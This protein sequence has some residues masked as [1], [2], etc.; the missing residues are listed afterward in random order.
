MNDLKPP[1]GL[2]DFLA[3]LF[4]GLLSLHAIVLIAGRGR[5]ALISALST[6]NAAFDAGLIVVVA[7][8][9]GLT[10]GV[11][12]RQFL[13]PLLWRWRHPRVEYFRGNGSASEPFGSGLTA[14]LQELACTRFD[15]PTLQAEQAYRLCR[16]YVAEN[17]PASW[18]RRQLMVAMR[19]MASHMVIPLTLCM[20]GLTANKQWPLLVC[21]AVVLVAL[22]SKTLVLEQREW[23]EIYTAFIVH[24]T[25]QPR[26]PR[27]EA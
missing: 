14:K 23:R 17:C 6:G 3:H 1:F 11:L 2:Y 10:A 7:Y 25:A 9:C 22:V 13:R 16:T 8:V 24:R 21:C 5:H 19:A 4:P 18:Q 15:D 26:V 12:A 20:V 27:E